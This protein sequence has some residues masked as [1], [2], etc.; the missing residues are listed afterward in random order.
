MSGVPG[1]RTQRENGIDA[2]ATTDEVISFGPFRLHAALR[3][4]EREG[5]V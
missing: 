4:I 2:G 1:E 5:V 3:L